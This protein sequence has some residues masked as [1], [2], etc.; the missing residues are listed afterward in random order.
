MAAEE[1]WYFSKELIASTPSRRCGIDPDRELSYRQ[2]AANF[3][4]DMGQRLKVTQLCINTAI[5]YMH[6]FYMFH[7][8]TVFH[9]NSIS[10]ASLFLAAKVEEQPRKLE[11]VI[12]V[13]HWCLNREG[14]LDT[15]SELY[16][17]NAQELV[18]NENVLLQTLGFDVGIDH[19]HTHVV[20]CCQL[21]RANKELAQTSYFMAS[22]SLHLTTM[23][24]EYRPTVVAC[25]CI[26]LACKWS[27]WEIPQSNEGKD[28]YSYV[29]STVTLEQLEQ[30]TAEFLVI[31]D[32]CPS[33]LKKMN[34][35]RNEES[36]EL[37]AMATSHSSN[38]PAEFEARRTKPTSS[39]AR[40]DNPLM[41]RST[42]DPKKPHPHQSRV[43]FQQYKEKKQREAA[44]A[45]AATAAAGKDG[46]PAPHHGP[47]PPV[48]ATTTAAPPLHHPN[49]KREQMKREMVAREREK[50]L[51]SIDGRRDLPHPRLGDTVPSAEVKRVRD[52]A[53]STQ[54]RAFESGSGLTELHTKRS[55]DESAPAPHHQLDPSR[56]NHMHPSSH[57]MKRSRD[58]NGASE[59]GYPP[60]VQAKRPREGTDPM[61][62]LLEPNKRPREPTDSTQVK[63]ELTEFDSSLTISSSRDNKLKFP[64]QE[65]AKA[66]QTK[67]PP[68]AGFSTSASQKH[69]HHKSEMNRPPSSNELDK[70]IPLLKQEL[71]KEKSFESQRPLGISPFVQRSKSPMDVKPD[72][73]SPEISRKIANVISGHPSSHLFS[74]EDDRED[75]ALPLDVSFSLEVPVLGHLV[76]NPSPMSRQHHQP[77][78]SQKPLSQELT[79]PNLNQTKS[80]VTPSKLSSAEKRMRT[81][82]SSSG[83]DPALV[84]VVRKLDETPGFQSLF[85]TQGTIKLEKEAVAVPLTPGK[86]SFA[87]IVKKETD[88]KSLLAES[89]AL[90]AVASNL[91]P[92]PV[93]SIFDPA[94]P[95]PL[96]PADI[97][98]DHH[99]KKKKKEKHGKKDKEK[100]KEEKKH[101][102]KKKDK[103][104]EK[105][106]ADE[107]TSSPV[108]APIKLTISKEKL[109]TPSVG[110]IKIKIPKERL[111]VEESLPSVTQ[112][113]S[114]GGIKFKIGNELISERRLPESSDAKKRNDN[115]QA[116]RGRGFKQ[117]G[118]QD[119]RK[120][121]LKGESGSLHPSP[122]CR[123]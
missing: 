122:G 121:P 59:S 106:S 9:R 36:Y 33:R 14:K 103:S 95:S 50:A 24:L 63:Q 114:S 78:S 43:D 47:R 38:M 6:R 62:D 96:A 68:I 7:S 30:L 111:K 94:E 28:W 48:P 120:V 72:V 19:P 99:H 105:R 100:S 3:I 42:E 25:F 117:N 71:A 53:D 57:A 32:K 15:K 5:V 11:H 58:S 90:P 10:T 61:M 44:A 37:M 31:Y 4:Q 97:R 101:K 22:N 39:S 16:L 81:S 67:M 118:H 73:K 107:A 77:N 70:L 1:K 46:R 23:C 41:Q 65:A 51:K 89:S 88:L 49:A 29:D 60:V 2:Q 79:Q 66:P 8:F 54:K 113:S 45:A 102:H 55:R 20:K 109:D 91:K 52:E 110:S 85:K 27:N 119:S 108:T 56:A 69:F 13:A 84:P 92:E 76:K 86:D 64:F 35:K 123:Q 18:F 74:P 82:S 40:P 87:P 75:S 21:V 112:M 83:S 104:K 116:S 17:E 12:T 115:G 80:P 93:P 98:N 34:S 26:H